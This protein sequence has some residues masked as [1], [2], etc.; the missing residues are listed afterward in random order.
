MTYSRTRWVQAAQ[1][2]PESLG[3]GSTTGPPPKVRDARPA[4]GLNALRPRRQRVDGGPTEKWK[5]RGKE[6]QSWDDVVAGEGSG[7]VTLLRAVPPVGLG[8]KSSV[9]SFPRITPSGLGLK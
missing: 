5:A 3:V 8:G 1:P 2:H 4:E 7:P 6:D 9:S